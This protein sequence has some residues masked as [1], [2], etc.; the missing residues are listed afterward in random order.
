MQHPEAFVTEETGITGSKLVIGCIPSRKARQV[1]SLKRL[2][3]L[4]LMQ[5]LPIYQPANEDVADGAFLGDDSVLVGEKWVQLLIQAVVLMG[6]SVK[7]EEKEDFSFLDLEEM[8]AFVMPR[9]A[10]VC[11]YAV[12]ANR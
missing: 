9:T 5:N 11:G 12:C 1:M 7:N 2:N 3:L 6:Q 8:F 4:S 10:F